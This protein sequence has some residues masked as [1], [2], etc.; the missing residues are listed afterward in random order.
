MPNHA[1]GSNHTFGNLM[2]AYGA[3]KQR[4]EDAH[5]LLYRGTEILALC[6]RAKFNPKPDQVWV[7]DDDEVAKWGERLAALKGNS[8]IP[9]Y[10]SP[11]GRT[12]YE[13]RG[14]HLITGDTT[15]K[16]DLEKARGPIPISRIVY[17]KP[18]PKSAIP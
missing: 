1:I 9:V 2:T 5:F 6:M 12:F 18:V 8:T 11:K 13:Y 10:Y 15:A 4:D 3:D 14:Q 17:I 7:G 16:V